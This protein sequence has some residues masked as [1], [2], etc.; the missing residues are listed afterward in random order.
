MVALRVWVLYPAILHVLLMVLQ[1]C[2]AAVFLGRQLYVRVR[3][4]YGGQ[5]VYSLPKYVQT[6]TV[7]VCENLDRAEFTDSQSSEIPEL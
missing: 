3:M 7:R 6:Y 2:T 5:Q 4:R 1:V